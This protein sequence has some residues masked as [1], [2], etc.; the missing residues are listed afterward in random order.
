MG[1]VVW[2]AVELRAWLGLTRAWAALWVS[3]VGAIVGVRRLSLPLSLKLFGSTVRG[4]SGLP[5]ARV[6]VNQWTPAYKYL[7]LLV[8]G[9]T[10]GGRLVLPPA[11]Q[12]GLTQY[13]YCFPLSVRCLMDEFV[14]VFMS[15]LEMERLVSLGKIKH[16]TE[17]ARLEVQCQKLR[18]W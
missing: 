2:M 4:F 15:L 8:Q 16:A 18:G 10:L 6:P 5:L 11:R 17:L 14:S 13:S 7:P 1:L 12:V 9:S 3:L